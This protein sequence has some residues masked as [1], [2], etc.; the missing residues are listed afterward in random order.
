MNWKAL[1]LVMP[2][3]MR[4][5]V[6]LFLAYCSRR[7]GELSMTAHGFDSV[8][9]GVSSIA[10]VIIAWLFWQSPELL[11]WEYWDSSPVE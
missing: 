3:V 6:V 10:L 5:A 7:I 4:M 1:P 9:M 8:A 11:T 2:H